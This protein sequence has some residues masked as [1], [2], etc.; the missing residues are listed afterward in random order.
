MTKYSARVDTVARLP[1][2][3]RQAFR[4]ATTGTPGPA[5]LELAGHMGELEQEAADLE[6]IAEP[7]FGRVPPLRIA[8]DPQAV[9]AAAQLL[10][11]AQRPIIVAGGG[12]RTSNAGAELRELA[13]R[14]AIPVATSL[15]AKDLLPGDHPLNVGVVG[16]YRATKRQSRR[17]RRGP[18][19]LH[20]QSHRQPGH[21]EMAG[22]AAR[23]DGHST[24]Y[25]S[26]GTRAALSQSRFTLGRC[27][28]RTSRLIESSNAGTAGRRRGWVEQVQTLARSGAEVAPQ[29]E[30]DAVPIRP[31]ESAMS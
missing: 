30:S 25:Q 23:H 12:A 11:A 29:T 27:Q 20:R 9:R 21:R 10:G 24:G 2:T 6:V 18:G 13:E 3:L 26:G 17:A 16:T 28:A 15:N 5:H 22:A 14:L 7:Q 4:A 31:S 1:D 19:V 8:P